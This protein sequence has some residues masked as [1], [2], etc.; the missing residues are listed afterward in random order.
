MVICIPVDSITCRAVTVPNVPWG[1]LGIWSHLLCVHA[2]GS[3]N[4]GTSKKQF[5][6]TE[7]GP[8]VGKQVKLSLQSPVGNCGATQVSL[9]AVLG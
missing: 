1:S 3:E 7:Q 2:Q 9:S 5:T 8:C 6:I 4:T